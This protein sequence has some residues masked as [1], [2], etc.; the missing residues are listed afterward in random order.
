M[1]KYKNNTIKE[2]RALTGLSQDQFSKAYGIPLGTLQHWEAGERKPPEYVIKLLEKVV[3][4][5]IK[6]E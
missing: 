6:D 4:H 1:T 2:I 5:E 3:K